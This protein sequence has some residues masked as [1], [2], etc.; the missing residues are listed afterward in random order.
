LSDQRQH[1][2]RTQSSPQGIQKWI[3]GRGNQFAPRFD[4][5]FSCFVTSEN[6]DEEQRQPGNDG[7]FRDHAPENEAVT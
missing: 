4:S 3:R 6:S 5:K 2:L 1:P 7:Q